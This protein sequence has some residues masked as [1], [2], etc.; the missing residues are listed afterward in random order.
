VDKDIDDVIKNIREQNAKYKDVTDRAAQTG[1]M[2]QVD[3]TGT[4]E[5]KA[6]AEISEKVKSLGEA[7][8]FWVI[9]DAENEFLPGF[10]AGLVGAKIGEKRDVV[11]KFA[12]DFAEQGVAGKTA[13]Y[14][15]DVKAIRE[16]DLP[17]LNEE[18]FKSLGVETEAA[19]RERIKEDMTKMRVDN[20]RSRVEGEILKSLLTAT[21]LD[22][23]ES[24]LAEE[25]QQ[26][27][28]DMVRSNTNRGI[29]KEE[30]E[31]NKEKLF[32]A[33]S[34]TAAE[35]IK[36]R[37][38]L[39]KIAS[40]EG[41]TATEAEINQRIAELAH[42]YQMTTEHFQ[43]DLEKNNALGRVADEVRLIKTISWLYDHAKIEVV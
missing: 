32:G 11:V 16:K 8:D 30:I 31:A 36:T 26:A 22:V 41:I 15:V 35:R 9:A 7:K 33:A 39:R 40:A 13:N 2:I 5:G 17:A 21:K 38:V 12:A 23:P 27:V 18:F 1:D 4:C 28:Y 25:T 24:V 3:F 19:M 20:E 6:F 37:Y 14:S 34:Q 42:R 10:S 29:A 43:K